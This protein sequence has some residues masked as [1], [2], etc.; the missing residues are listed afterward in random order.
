MPRNADALLDRSSGALGTE[1]ARVSGDV[2]PG[3]GRPWGPHPGVRRRPCELQCGNVGP[4]TCGRLGRSAL[5]RVGGLH[6]ATRRGY[7]RRRD[8]PDAPT[9]PSTTAH[10]TSRCPPIC[11]SCTASSSIWPST[12]RPLEEMLPVAAEVRIFPLLQ[13]GGTPSPHVEG[14]VDAFGSRGADATV[15]PV[16]YEFQRGGNRMLRLRRR[17]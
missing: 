13:I 5:C 14:V 11:S 4:R 8:G 3:R 15:E 12:S 7:F 1:C 2:C 17:R 16:A 9:C 6:T 10:S